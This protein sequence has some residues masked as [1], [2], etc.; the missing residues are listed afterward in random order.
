MYCP[1]CGSTQA[2][3]L[4]YCKACGAN[5]QAVR[6]ALTKVTADDEG[7]DWNKTWLAEAVMTQEE[8]DRRRGVTPE[9][10]RRREIKAGVIT[11]AVGIGLTLVLSVILEAVVINGHIS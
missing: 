3:E 10:K 1:K 11:V 6:G 7:L 4:N 8:R 5:L 2:D 9:M